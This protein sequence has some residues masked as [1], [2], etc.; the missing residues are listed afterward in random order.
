MSACRD[1][2]ALL[3]SLLIWTSHLSR[4]RP[5]GL[6]DSIRASSS[7][8]LLLGCCLRLFC[9]VPPLVCSVSS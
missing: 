9:V 6:A 4:S 7:V 3:F 5:R 8:S 2:V 1:A